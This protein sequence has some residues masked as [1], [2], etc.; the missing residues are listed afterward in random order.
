MLETVTFKSCIV[1]T[2]RGDGSLTFEDRENWHLGVETYIPPTEEGQD[3]E[4]LCH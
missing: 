4:Y 3:G 2:F 1:V